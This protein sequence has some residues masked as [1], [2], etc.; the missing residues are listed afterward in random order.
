MLIV[1]Q[2]HCS[3][4]LECFSF[5][6][7]PMSRTPAAPPPHNTVHLKTPRCVCAIAGSGRRSLPAGAL[8]EAGAR[9]R[10]IR[11][12]ALPVGPSLLPLRTGLLTGSLIKCHAC[13]RLAMCAHLQLHSEINY[14]SSSAMEKL[15][16][17]AWSDWRTFFP[18]RDCG[19]DVEAR[20]ASAHM[21]AGCRLRGGA[22]DTALTV[23]RLRKPHMHNSV[24][25]GPSR[26]LNAEHG[27]GDVSGELSPVWFQAPQNVS[28][29]PLPHDR[30]QAVPPAPDA[31]QKIE[32]S[33]VVCFCWLAAWRWC[34]WRGRCKRPTRRAPRVAS[35]LP[36]TTLPRYHPFAT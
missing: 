13:P 20:K 17:A 16:F 7:A 36:C 14:L 33:E 23:Q 24:R 34:R 3:A 32:R 9:G 15:C 35:A 19:E 11:G 6:A 12:A 31:P 28:G 29:E 1:W 22:A 8:A 27:G 4:S 21:P 25:C 10:Q 5:S 26:S 18:A 2:G 30:G